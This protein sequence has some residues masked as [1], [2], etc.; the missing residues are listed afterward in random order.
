M[1]ELESN[2]QDKKQPYSI[3]FI[4]PNIDYTKYP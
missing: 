1:N 3:L 2:T 4:K